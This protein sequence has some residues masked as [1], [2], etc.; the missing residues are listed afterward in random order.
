MAQNNPAKS[1][2]IWTRSEMVKRLRKFRS[3]PNTQTTNKDY[4]FGRAC[5]LFPSASY[6]QSE[7]QKNYALLKCRYF[8]RYGTEGSPNIFIRRSNMTYP[9]MRH[10]DHS[11]FRIFA[12]SNLR[13]TNKLRLSAYPKKM[14]RKV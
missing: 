13:G 14:A 9:L 5:V 7:S 1:T 4:Y 6:I 8:H 3:T 2:Q 10:S 11:C 12:L